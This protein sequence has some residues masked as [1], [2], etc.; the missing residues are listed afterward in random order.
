MGRTI[1]WE[2]GAVVTI[3]Q[4][5]LPHHF[6]TIR[7]RTMPQVLEAIRTMRIRGAPIIGVASAY[8]LA[9][10]AYRGRHI[11]K[12]RL[13]R[14]LRKAGDLL[15]SSRPTG[16]DMHKAVER[17][18]SRVATANGDI[19]HVTL[20]EAQAI[21]GEYERAERQLVKNG[22]ILIEDGDVVL[23]HCNSGP[24][25]TVAW[26]TGLGIL[27]RA[28]KS[29]KRISVIAT[30][31]RPMLQGARLTAW[32]LKHNGVPFRLVT[33]D[34]VGYVMAR[35]LVD[36]VLVGA[37]RVWSDGS[38]ANKIGTLTIA[39]LAKEYEIPF[40]VAVPVSTFDLESTPSYSI[41]EMRDP[42]EILEIGR[43][44]IAPLGTKCLNP[45]F[46]ITPANHITAIVTEC[47]VLHPPFR[48]SI[49]RVLSGQDHTGSTA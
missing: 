37:D 14:R 27:L 33:D 29:G 25:A 48:R 21:A 16:R 34:M 35:G 43:E 20:L 6:K 41:V 26:G 45:A 15:R 7:L 23:T 3:D 19:G 31:T 38:V 2:K 39:S 49:G 13:V 36:K 18:L 10:E 24:L 1:R 44:R 47:G 42:K 11:P 5:L 4:T 22:Q 40:Y 17:V 12:E 32:E 30:E 8:A 9:L 28:W 46:D